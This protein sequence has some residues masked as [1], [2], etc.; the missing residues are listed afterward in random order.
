MKKLFLFLCA[1]VLSAL[2]VRPAYA[3]E[4]PYLNAS[5]AGADRVKLWWSE[6]SMASYQVL[7]GP[8][9]SPMAHGVALGEGENYTVGG[10]FRNTWYVFVVKAVKGNEVSAL[11]NSVKVWVGESGRMAAVAP[12]VAPP[13]MPKTPAVS[14]KPELDT[15]QTDASLNSPYI[16]S[17]KPGVGHLNLR[18]SRGVV[19][20]TVVLHWNEPVMPPASGNYNIVY[21]DDPMVEKWGVLNV[22]RDARSY[23]IGG[24]VSGR[25]YWFWMATTNWGRTPWVS[26][27]AR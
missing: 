3:L 24:L 15:M 22:S 8:V 26:D 2:A 1:A 17:G 10:L 23:T 7:Y 27:L 6:V 12:A 25:R 16:S 19:P 21:T 20:G 18:T 11:S 13:G 4:A 9:G 5:S 14:Y